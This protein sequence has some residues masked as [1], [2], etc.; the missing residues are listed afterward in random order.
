VRFASLLVPLALAGCAGHDCE[1]LARARWQI[2]PRLDEVER[3]L[4]LGG[5]REL[6][7]E[8]ARLKGEIDAIQRAATAGNC[9]D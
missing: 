7:A 9:A 5:T 3:R 8:C 6:E 4:Q 2:Q 1:Q